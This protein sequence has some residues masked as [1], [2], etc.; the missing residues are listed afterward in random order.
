MQEFGRHEYFGLAHVFFALAVGAVVHGL[1]SSEVALRMKYRTL[2]DVPF[3]EFTVKFRVPTLLVSVAP[4]YHTRM[5]DVAC[6]H[7]LDE[8][9]SVDGFM[10]AVPTAKLAHHIQSETVASVIEIRVGRVVR[11]A[12]GVHVHALDKLHVGYVELLVQRA[13]CLRPEAVAVHTTDVYLL[14]VDVEAI[15]GARFDCP[16]AELVLL[17]VERFAVCVDQSESYLVAVWRFGSPQFGV[18]HLERHVGMVAARPHV[19]GVFGYFLAAH[20]ADGGTYLSPFERVVEQNERVERTVSPG[21]D[22]RTLN[23]YCRFAHNEHRAE[24]AAEV[25]IVGTALGKVDALVGAFL[26]DCYLEQVFLVAEEHAVGYV[27]GE[28]VERSLVHRACLA[29]VDHNLGVGHRALKHEVDVVVG[30]LGRQRELI[31]VHAFLV[32]NAVWERFAV[33]LHAVLVSA[34][35]LKFPARRY[36]DFC[37]LA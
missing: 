11:Q 35:A 18:V 37:P 31:L 21:I 32:C 22:G 27:I 34:E 12:N 14:A 24:D 9:L 1:V 25:P 15:S 26:A 29:L 8:L 30:P 10:V 36:A 20:V 5:V 23:V 3:V 4:P 6:N 2:L 19:G 33:K 7:F 13:S 17:N 16:E 28:A